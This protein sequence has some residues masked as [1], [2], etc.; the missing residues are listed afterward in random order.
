MKAI[1][2]RAR[3]DGSFDEVGMNNRT[4]IEGK[5]RKDLQKKAVKY[6]NGS[7]VRVEFYYENVYTKP[8]F[9]VYLEKAAS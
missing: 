2:T 1:I 8:L 5:S 6:G 4:I 7:P 9:V 3:L